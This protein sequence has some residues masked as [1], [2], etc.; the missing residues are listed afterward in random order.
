[1]DASI[2]EVAGALGAE[3]V[4]AIDHNVPDL[5]ALPPDVDVTKTPGY[6]SGIIILQ[7]K[8]SCFPAYLL[9]GV[10]NDG[11]SVGDCID[12]CAAPGNKTSH[13][14]A[15]LSRSSESKS[16]SKIYACERDP[17]RSKTLET[18]MERSG[19]GT[20][21]VK[22]ECDFLTLD[23]H[24]R[25]FN[26]VTHLLLDPSCSGSGILG[27]ED[28]PALALPDDTKANNHMPKSKKRK[29]N[30]DGAK[31]VET[32]N[33]TST[34]DEETRDTTVDKERLRKL[35][36]LQTRIVEH[37]LSFPAAVRVTY[38][39]C[40]VHVEENEAVVARVLASTVAKERGWHLLQRDKQVSGLRSWPHRGISRSELPMGEALD[41][42][43]KNLEACIRC[44]PG[45]AEGTM[46]FF[47]CCFVRSAPEQS[48]QAADNSI[49]EAVSWEGFND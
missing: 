7:D 15:L 42:Q 1:M 21:V 20:V 8:A 28:M 44:H 47:V 23:P 17:K 38:S 12:A 27:R 39:T 11:N 46:G 5:I 14:A 25:Q 45:D 40:S 41:L 35:S 22:A 29:R 48:Q 6:E 3:K 2:T 18:M 10:D 24:H 43:E 33:T 26:K 13:L 32:T 37:A 34:E 4:L 19:A 9:V 36:N 49:D 30:S 31:P 16:K